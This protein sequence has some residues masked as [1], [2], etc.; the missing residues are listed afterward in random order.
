M[1]WLHK[2]RQ[3]F[4]SEDFTKSQKAS[5]GALKL[6]GEALQWWEALDY[7]I[8]EAERCVMTWEIFSQ[9]VQ[10][11]FCPSGH[12]WR[13]E[14]EFFALEKA[15]MLVGKY[16]TMLYERL[17]FANIYCPTEAKRVEHY[18]KRL[19]TEYQA[20]MMHRNTLAAAMDKAIQVKVDLATP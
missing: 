9:K 16:N 4:H 7:V 3:I 14:Q 12:M 18:A 6:Y 13:I 20:T 8:L 15:T 1:Q 2:M 17:Q 11:S 10:E 19:P 5:Y